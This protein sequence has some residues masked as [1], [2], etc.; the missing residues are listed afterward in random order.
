MFSYFDISCMSIWRRRKIFLLGPNLY[1]TRKI[2][3]VWF[4]IVPYSIYYF[5]EM[6]MIFVPSM[7]DLKKFQ[8]PW[9]RLRKFITGTVG[10]IQT[11]CSNNVIRI[12]FQDFLSKR[13]I[14]HHFSFIFYTN[15]HML[16]I[17]KRKENPFEHK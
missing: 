16:N 13:L 3:W 12:Q 9:L 1:R 17:T 2:I 4:F 15:P 14:Q 6:H 11:I 10:R 7:I 5:L 8:E